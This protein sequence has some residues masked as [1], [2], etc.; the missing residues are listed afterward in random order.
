[1]DG[2]AGDIQ[3][4]QMA[5]WPRPPQS[6]ASWPSTVL[7]R[8]SGRL[9]GL[10][11]HAQRRI[12]LANCSMATASV[13]EAIC[14]CSRVPGWSSRADAA[15]SRH[16]AWQTALRKVG[17]W[18]DAWFESRLGGKRRPDVLTCVSRTS[19]YLDCPALHMASAAKSPGKR[20][21]AAV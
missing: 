3:P 17:G 13:H 18:S 15:A 9:V 10:P 6:A 16:R 4:I 20:R 7:S 12:A 19:T 5:A 11:C 8:M 14:R 1:M 2:S 21:L